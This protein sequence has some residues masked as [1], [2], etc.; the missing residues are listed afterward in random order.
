M[1]FQKQTSSSKNNEVK[2]I[3]EDLEFMF[4]LDN[5]DFYIED[6][7]CISF[8]YSVLETEG[9]NLTYEIKLEVSIEEDI[10]L[11]EEESLNFEET[12]ETIKEEIENVVDEK[13]SDKLDVIDDNLPQNEEIFR[14]LE[15]ENKI[16]KI[17][18]FISIVKVMFIGYNIN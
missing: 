6:I 1:S 9:I 11:R 12:L 18:A 3:S 16:I 5:E 17:V 15:N 14:S 7:E 4:D 10:D 2:L 8:D 13:L